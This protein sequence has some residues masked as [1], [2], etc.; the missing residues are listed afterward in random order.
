[1]SQYILETCEIT[2]KFGNFLANDGINLGIE[3]GKIHAIAGENG[4]GKSTL[5]KMIYGVYTITSGAI[6]VDGEVQKEWNPSIAREKGIGMVF[7]DFRLISAFSV[8]ENICLSLQQQGFF[9]HKKQLRREIINV[10]HQ[11]G[12]KIDPDEEVWRMDLGERQHIEI[13]KVLMNKNARIM[14]FDEP[15]SVLAPHEVSTFLEM[16]QRFRDNGY[17]IVLITH[18][19]NEIIA[20]A[21][22]ITVLR[23]GKKVH[24]FYKQ[25]EYSEQEIVGKML[26]GDAS[27][28]FN[29]TYK[30]ADLNFSNRNEFALCNISISDDH[31]RI[32]LKHVNAVLRPGRIIG[33]AGISGNGQKE[34]SEA[35]YGIRGFS[36]GSMFYGDENITRLNTQ[37]RI[38]RGIRMVTEDPLRDNVV[39]NFTI[40]E[41]MVLA[42]LEVKVKRG[43][44][45]WT[46]MRVQLEEHKEIKEMGVPASDRIVKELSGG[47][48]QRLAFAR[49]VINKPNL[50]VACYPT[51][52][53]DVRTVNTVHNTL[54]DLC[55]AGSVILLISEDLSELYEMSDELLVL[56]GHTSFGPF[57]PDE[58]SMSEIGRLML[59]GDLGDGSEDKS[60]N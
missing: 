54:K 16:L 10:S 40:L 52:G 18:K 58:H 56:A 46:A 25:K 57:L 51:R 23:N 7:Q 28:L 13:I 26:G 45:D 41:N 38:K 19:I 47:N 14:I 29:K 60:I 43:N 32:I 59:R 49:A 37:E 5:M 44:I 36:K 4:A 34:L 53:L 11:Y 27:I 55:A 6:I 12:L 35:I 3:A 24:T 31:N 8:L 2:K 21:D 39:P 1:M 20:V 17:A 42:G 15:T 50:V 33:V 30:K 9:V 48:V 22:C